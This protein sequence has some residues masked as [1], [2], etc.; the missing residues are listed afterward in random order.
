MS[1]VFVPEDGRL[2]AASGGSAFALDPAGG[3]VLWRTNDLKGMSH[4]DGSHLIVVGPFLVVGGKGHVVC[5]QR[6]SGLVVWVNG[7][8]GCDHW[9]VTLKALRLQFQQPPMMAP[10]VP[11]AVYPTPD[12]PPMMPAA[13]V[14]GYPTPP[15]MVAPGYP[16]PPMMATP[17]AV[18]APVMQTPSPPAQVQDIVLACTSGRVVALSMFDGH[19]LWRFKE[20]PRGGSGTSVVGPDREGKLWVGTGGYVFKV[21]PATGDILWKHNLKSTLYNPVGMALVDNAL[22]NGEQVLFA[23]C[24]GR[25]F[26]ISPARCEQLWVNKM[27]GCGSHPGLSLVPIPP[28][29]AYGQ[30]PASIAVG[31]NGKVALLSTTGILQKKTSLPGCGYGH[32]SLVFDH[33]L[34]VLFASSQGHLY[35]LQPNAEIIWHSDLPGLGHEWVSMSN[36]RVTIDL[37]ACTPLGDMDEAAK[38]AAAA[39]AAH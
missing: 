36:M 10:A 34:G 21:E 15:M 18:A 35:A 39:A 13:A 3:S 23:A 6:G 27:P 8:P 33:T 1:T 9:S 4:S 24:L 2:Y 30:P 20:T 29:G 16:T 12:A 26:A 17:P 32:V 28:P 19:E 31:I 7:L 38:Q 11:A 37:H 25:A 22:G 14:P 5:L